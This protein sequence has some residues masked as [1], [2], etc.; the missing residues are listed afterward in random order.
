[1]ATSN[2][3]N[4]NA[5]KI[6]AIEDENYS[7]KKKLLKELL[8]NDKNFFEQEKFDNKRNFEGQI[9]GEFK[10]NLESCSL[11]ISL[12]IRSGYYSGANL[13]F[14]IAI[15]DFQGDE[16]SNFEELAHFLERENLKFKKQIAQLKKFQ[17][18]TI[19]KLEK[20]YSQVSCQKL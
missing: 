2:F 11:K 18:D 19:K 16:C 7:Y 8:K 12:V 3:Y 10:L 1:M 20:I 9:L 14:E 6:F 15:V 5:S 17:K 4:K 13:D